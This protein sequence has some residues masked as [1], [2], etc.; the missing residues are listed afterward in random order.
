MRCLVT[1]DLLVLRPASKKSG[2]EETVMGSGFRIDEGPT[3]ARVRFSLSKSY[4]LGWYD[5][6]SIQLCPETESWR[7]K[8][9]GVGMMIPASPGWWE[10]CWALL[11]LL[12]PHPIL[13]SV[14]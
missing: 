6:K 4:Q 14:R 8:I 5:D 3:R 7:G 1:W 13:V 12:L 9:V 11:K 2:F 10:H